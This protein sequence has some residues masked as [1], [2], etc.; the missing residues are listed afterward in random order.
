MLSPIPQLASDS[1]ID[2]LEKKRIRSNSI[3]VFSFYCLCFF[4]ILNVNFFTRAFIGVEQACCPHWASC[5]RSSLKC[6]LLLGRLAP[7]G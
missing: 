6:V 1:P 3:G 2:L 7:C 5:F 4:C